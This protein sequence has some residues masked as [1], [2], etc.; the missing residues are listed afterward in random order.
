[1]PSYPKRQS[2]FAHK[3]VRLMFKS[4][5]AADIG[6]PAVAMLCHIAHL[7]DAARYSGPIRCW[8]EQL[9]NVF[10]LSDDSLRRLRDKCV[11]AAE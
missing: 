2:H 7:E 1:M 9:S 5:L 11:E 10:G 4:C 8:N 3:A 6:M